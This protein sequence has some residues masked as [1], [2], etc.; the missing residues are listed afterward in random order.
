MPDIQEAL[1]FW[2]EVYARAHA[3]RIPPLVMKCDF[4]LVIGAILDR[5]R[6]C[7]TLEELTSRYHESNDWCVELAKRVQPDKPYTWRLAVVEDI[8]YWERACELD[9]SLIEEELSVPSNLLSQSNDPFTALGSFRFA[10]SATNCFF[11]ASE[12]H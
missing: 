6:D 3:Q 5:L 2:R 7:M 9:P 11:R 8:A 1:C 10:L 12:C 4:G